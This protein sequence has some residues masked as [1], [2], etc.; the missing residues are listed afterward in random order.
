MT[1]SGINLD[2]SEN[3]RAGILTNALLIASVCL[4]ALMRDPWALDSGKVPRLLALYIILAG[5]F[6]LMFFPALRKCLDWS[7]ASHKV[8]FAFAAYTA[9]VWVSLFQA[10]NVNLFAGYLMLLLPICILGS[11]ILRGWWK[12]LSVVCALHTAYLLILLQTRSAWLG[13]AFCVAVFVSVACLRPVAFGWG[14]R[15][16]QSSFFK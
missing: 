4:L 13:S 5:F 2:S 8:L 15:L 12:I 14:L 1:S 9:A 16:R 3:R 6:V 7:A 11:A 10:G